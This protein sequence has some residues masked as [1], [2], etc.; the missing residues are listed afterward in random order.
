MPKVPSDVRIA[1]RK[2]VSELLRGAMSVIACEV[3]RARG[4]FDAVIPVR[5]TAM[6]PVKRVGGVP[7]DSAT[8][9]PARSLPLGHG[10]ADRPN[11]VGLPPDASSRVGEALAGGFMA[12]A[13]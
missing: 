2:A 12:L 5:G 1:I 3:R 4:S 9:R 13:Q 8:W 11:L 7:A 10:H 6:R